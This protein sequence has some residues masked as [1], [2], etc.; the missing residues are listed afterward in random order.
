LC[1]GGTFKKDAFATSFITN[2]NPFSYTS[3]DDSIEIRILD[4]TLPYGPN[5]DLECADIGSLQQQQQQ[6]QLNFDRTSGKNFNK[7]YFFSLYV[8]FLFDN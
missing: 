1:T 7:Y 2:T 8:F 5:E 3:A 6:S 4:P